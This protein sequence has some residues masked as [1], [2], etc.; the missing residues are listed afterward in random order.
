[1]DAVVTLAYIAGAVVVL[2]ILSQ[3]FVMNATLAKILVEMQAPRIGNAVP[4]STPVRIGSTR[5]GRR[6]MIAALTAACVMAA[7]AV[8]AGIWLGPRLSL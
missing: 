6:A 3:L 1:M 8:V 7:I 4:D 5:R 2:L